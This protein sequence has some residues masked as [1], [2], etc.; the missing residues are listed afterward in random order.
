MAADAFKFELVGL[1]QL[2][3]NME[4]LPTASMKKTVVWNALKKALVPVREAAK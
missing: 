3:K 4:E 2:L 1:D